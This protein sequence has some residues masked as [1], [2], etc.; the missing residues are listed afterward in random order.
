MDDLVVLVVGF[1]LIKKAVPP[2]VLQECRDQAN[3]AEVQRNTQVR[4]LARFA[5]FVTIAF[6]W[7]ILA[8]V[9]SLMV[10]KHFL[11]R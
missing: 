1:K 3:A 8:I 11:H 4:S 5:V 2:Q 6:V 7:F 9:G 10:A